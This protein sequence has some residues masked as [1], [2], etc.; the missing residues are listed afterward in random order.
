MIACF[1]LSSFV[2][3]L[4]AFICSRPA[5]VCFV[6][7]HGAVRYRSILSWEWHVCFASS[8]RLVVLARSVAELLLRLGLRGG[9]IDGSSPFLHC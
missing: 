5:K 9:G 2:C 6:F 7:R 3:G 4:H 8:R 1:S